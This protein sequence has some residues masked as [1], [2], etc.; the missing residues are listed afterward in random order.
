MSSKSKTKMNTEERIKRMSAQLNALTQKE[1]LR[2]ERKRKKAKTPKQIKIK[3][4]K[5]L[6][7]LQGL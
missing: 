5:G 4:L 1:A 7:G 2:L 3:G 6:Q